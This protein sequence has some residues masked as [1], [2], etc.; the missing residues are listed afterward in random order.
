MES[1]DKDGSNSFSK[2]VSVTFGDKQSFSI[3][4]N[5][6][7]DFATISFSQTMDKAT[8]AVYDISGKAVITESLIGNTNTYK[9]NTLN[10][11]NG[12]YLIKVSTSTSTFNEKLIINK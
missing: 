12:I 7:R 8:I 5:P 9:L 6:A 11:K 3:I 2:V 4:P 1:V 10:L